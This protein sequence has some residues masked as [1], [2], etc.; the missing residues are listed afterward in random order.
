[1]QSIITVPM[2]SHRLQSHRPCCSSFA[3]RWRAAGRNLLAALG[4]LLALS[5]C[6]GTEGS[7]LRFRAVTTTNQDFEAPVLVDVGNSPI[8]LAGADLDGDLDMDLLV[9]NQFETVPASTPANPFA[10]GT[11]SLLTNDGAG[12]FTVVEEFSTGGSLPSTILTGNF[13]GDI[14]PDIVLLNSAGSVISVFINDG[15]GSFLPPVDYLLSGTATQVSLI[16]LDGDVSTPRDLIVSVSTVFDPDDFTVP[17]VMRAFVNND[18]GSGSLTP[19]DIAGATGV[20]TRFVIGD[21]N[22][23]AIPDLAVIE[24]EQDAVVV[25]TGDSPGV[26]AFTTTGTFPQLGT[27]YDIVTGD[28]NND[29]DA[30]LVVSNR[31]T[32]FVSYLAGAGAGTLK[33]TINLE[34]VFWGGMSGQMIVGNP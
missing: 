9:V 10:P 6:E 13:D 1:M 17:G 3:A 5:A 22:G 20:P 2:Q 25:L 8:T 30:D 32:S 15:M 27:A 11:I 18:D 19:I 14:Y 24:S 34:R 16:D 4:A 33:P 26:G 7:D 31:F 29:G 12:T 28:F 21:W 23:D